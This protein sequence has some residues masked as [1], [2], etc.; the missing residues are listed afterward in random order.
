MRRTSPGI[1]GVSSAGVSCAMSA[2]RPTSVA[3]RGPSPPPRTCRRVLGSTP[4]VRGSAT[5]DVRA[6]SSGRPLALDARAKP[7]GQSA[8]RPAC[9]A[10]FRAGLGIGVGAARASPWCTIGS[11][12]ASASAGAPHPGSATSPPEPP[13]TR[14]PN[15]RPLPRPR[16]ASE[17]GGR[18][19]RACRALASSVPA[20][21]SRRERRV[22][23]RRATNP[24]HA[25]AFY[26]ECAHVTC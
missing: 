11:A 14:P 7:S 18:R 22:F 25:V 16:P 5:G 1:R 3:R 15:T 24:L 20:S 13:A 12:G 19:G 10:S 17:P 9:C 21:L 4:G 8:P 2:A 23:R 26:V 6:E